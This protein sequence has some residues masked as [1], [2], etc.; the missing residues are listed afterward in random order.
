[1]LPWT[2]L[3]PLLA[4]WIRRSALTAPLAL[5]RSLHIYFA[6]WGLF[7]LV[8]F[9]LLSNVL[10][11]YVLPAVAPLSCLAGVWLARR[12]A[13]S[14]I[15]RTLVAGV[16]FSMLVS[17][18]A[19]AYIG[20]TNEHKKISTEA[21]VD[22]WA[23]KAQAG[24]PLYFYLWVPQSSKFYTAGQAQLFKTIPDIE[25]AIGSGQPMLI[26]LYDTQ[27][28]ALDESLLSQLSNPQKFGRYTLFELNWP[29]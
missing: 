2:V 11:A 1:M 5:H 8:F 22:T 19:V 14:I 10:I 7:L 13:E 3:L 9:S 29:K 12:Q 17:L 16:L 28:R 4:W 18:V 21:L 26:A 24:E 20:V 6:L 15:R 25:Q 23:N 27:M